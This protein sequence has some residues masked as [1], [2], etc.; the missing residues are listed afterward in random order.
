MVGIPLADALLAVPPLGPPGSHFIQPIM[1]QAE[2]SG[3]APRLLS[4]LLHE[5]APAPRQVGTEL[6]RVAAWS[7]LQEP[8]DHAALRLDA[9]LDDAAGRH[10]VGHPRRLRTARRRQCRGIDLRRR[11]PRRAAG[12]ELLDPVWSPPRPTVGTFADAVQS[13]PDE[14]AAWVWHAPADALG[15]IQIDLA[16]HAAQHHDAHLVKYTLA[17]F[18]AAANDPVEKR[19]YTAACARLHAWWMAQE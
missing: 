13:S 9:L 19:L 2:D 17:C 7:M 15:A 14:A 18:D 5:Q 16:L 3:V 8:I 1:A 4:G 10:G 12:T 11:I 6:A